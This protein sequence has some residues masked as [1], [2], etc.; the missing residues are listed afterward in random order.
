MTLENIYNSEV[1]IWDF[2]I[3]NRFSYLGIA[4]KRSS[5]L[6][7]ENTGGYFRSGFY[8]KE[9]VDLSR[10]NSISIS[11]QAT[12]LGGSSGTRKAFRLCITDNP[13]DNTYV[14]FVDTTFNSSVPYEFSLDVSEYGDSFYVCLILINDSKAT[15]KATAEVN[16]VYIETNYVNKILIQSNSEFYSHDGNEWLSLGNLPE[17][18]EERNDF[19]FEHGMLEITPEQAKTLKKALPNGKGKISVMRL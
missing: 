11:L 9:K 3:N 5:S 7:M 18:L 8:S 19:Y 17:D 2:T 4:E 14:K 12:G 10:I 1:D 15:G 13:F 6:Y 16:S